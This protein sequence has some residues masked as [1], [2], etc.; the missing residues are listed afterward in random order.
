MP[1][2][3]LENAFMSNEDDLEKLMDDEFI[4][5]LAEQICQSTIE[6]LNKTVE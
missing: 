2:I 6:A 5:K 3:I 4:F 1:A